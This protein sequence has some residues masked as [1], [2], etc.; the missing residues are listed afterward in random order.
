MYF[1][2]ELLARIDEFAKTL[3][4]RL[5]RDGTRTDAVRLLLVEGLVRHEKNEN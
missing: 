3:K 5:G 2:E 1:S 4:E